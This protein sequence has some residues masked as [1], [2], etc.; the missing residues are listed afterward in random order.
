MSERLKI[1]TLAPETPRIYGGGVRAY[2][3]ARALTTRA[4]V[5]LWVLNKEVQ[6]GLP[7]DLRAACAWVRHLPSAYQYSVPRISGGKSLALRVPLTLMLPWIKGGQNALLAWENQALE[8]AA[9]LSKGWRSV[10]R[11]VYAKLLL[12][13]VKFQMRLFGLLPR[14]TTLH[15]EGYH[16][17]LPEMLRQYDGAAPDIIW[18]EHSFMFPY[19]KDLLRK[20][21]NARLICNAHNVEYSLQ[22]RIAAV[23]KAPSVKQWYQIQANASRRLEAVA[24]RE[25]GLVFCCSEEDKRLILAVAPR[26]RVAV[27]PNGVDVHYFRPT[28]GRT[29]T[30]EPRLI[31]TGGMDYEPNR[32]AVRFLVAE[33]LPLVRRVWSDCRFCIAGSAAQRNFG[34]LASTDPL[35][36]IASDVPDMRPYFEKSSV[37]VVPLRSGSGTRTKILEAMAMECAIVSTSIGAE[38]IPCQAGKHILLADRPAEF[39]ESVVRLL[40]NEA[41][42]VQIG[43]EAGAWVRENYDWNLLCAK[44][45]ECLE[46]HLPA[47][48]GVNRRSEKTGA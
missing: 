5:R 17:L 11:R 28:H 25:C 20:F 12:L 26:A 1:L 14:H 2:H 29:E 15:A 42:R 41:L 21:P 19:A 16:V 4:E 10:P 22:Q 32:D 39:A 24:F 36:E 33:I 46:E 37:V 8:R 23:A 45:Y 6:P 43:R 13:E 7:P 9:D 48:F 30:A 3:F 40:D 35:I 34:Y 44:A 47:A 27:I 31:F 18:F 38:G